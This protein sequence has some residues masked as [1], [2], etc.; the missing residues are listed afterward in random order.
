MANEEAAQPGERDAAER[1]S[2]R[3]D[4][5]RALPLPAREAHA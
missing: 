3:S 1:Q 5:L 4:F 2:R